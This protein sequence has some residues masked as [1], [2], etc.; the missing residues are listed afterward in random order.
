MDKANVTRLTPAQDDKAKIAAL[1]QGLYRGSIL[2][3]DC[4]TAEDVKTLAGNVHAAATLARL[5]YKG[6]I[7]DHYES[8]TGDGPD[9]RLVGDVLDLADQLAF[10]LAR[11]LGADEGAA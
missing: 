7:A 4:T 11:K 9:E 10:V 2:N 3:W 5:A 6:L 1:R 8:G